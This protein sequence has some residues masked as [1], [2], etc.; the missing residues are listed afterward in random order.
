MGFTFV[1]KFTSPESRVLVPFPSKNQNGLLLMCDAVTFMHNMCAACAVK[2]G[3]VI[4][5]CNANR[6]LLNI[7]LDPGY[8]FP[9]F[10]TTSGSVV[11]Q[12]RSCGQVL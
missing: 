9:R 7:V 3:V 8:A 4:L 6:C 10:T 5:H 11:V 12:V 2:S 1:S